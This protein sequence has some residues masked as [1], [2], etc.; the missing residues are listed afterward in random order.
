[1]TSAIFVG[2]LASSFC[3]LGMTEMPELGL[4]KEKWG[5]AELCLQCWKLAS[6]RKFAGSLSSPY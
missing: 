6:S 4:T 1:M 3:L 2:A 5:L